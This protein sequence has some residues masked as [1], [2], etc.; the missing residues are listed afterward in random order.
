MPGQSDRTQRRSLAPALSDELV[1]STHEAPQGD[2]GRFNL[3]WA[4]DAGG[5][6]YDKSLKWV[7]QTFAIAAASVYNVA[8][9]VDNNGV[10]SQS[11]V[12]SRPT[13]ELVVITG[14]NLTV[15][16]VGAG[17]VSATLTAQTLLRGTWYTI[18]TAPAAFAALGSFVSLPLT[19]FVISP[20]QDFRFQFINAAGG[21]VTFTGYVQAF[22][23]TEG[24][25]IPR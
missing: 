15:A 18:W 7:F 5:W 16:A 12:R 1:V 2:L 10:F 14:W 9:R 20:D 23:A 4:L 3:T 19:R 25:Q 11:F 8:L 17:F 21:T 24:A 6:A 22:M 13:R